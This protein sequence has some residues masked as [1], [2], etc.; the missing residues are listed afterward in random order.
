MSHRNLSIVFGPTLM[1]S[2]DL[3]NQSTVNLSSMKLEEEIACIREL[4][5]NFEDI[6]E[7]RKYCLLVL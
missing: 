3:N 1:A 5:V 4:L 6:F 7:V 2:I